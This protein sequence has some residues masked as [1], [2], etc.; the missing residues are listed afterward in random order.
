MARHGRLPARYYVDIPGWF[1]PVNEGLLCL[2]KVPRN[3]RRIRANG[4]H[5]SS[6]FR[7]PAASK[8][9]RIPFDD[10]KGGIL[11]VTEQSVEGIHTP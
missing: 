2:N 8:V 7:D 1:S 10:L 3:S 6:N 4:R 5:V 9:R 11:A